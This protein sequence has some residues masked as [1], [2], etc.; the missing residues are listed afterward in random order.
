MAFCHDI[1]E[2]LFDP[3][4]SVFAAF[5]LA[6]IVND[7]TFIVAERADIYDVDEALEMHV[8]KHLY[9]HNFPYFIQGTGKSFYT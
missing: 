6:L 7:K 4:M 5:A 1:P 3:R 8:T 9:L 2:I